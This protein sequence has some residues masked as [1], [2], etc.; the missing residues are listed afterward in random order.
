[1]R[2]PGRLHVCVAQSAL[3]WVLRNTPGHHVKAVLWCACGAV[4]FPGLGGRWISRNVRRAGL[5][6]IPT[7][8]RELGQLDRLY[9]AQANR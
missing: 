8:H 4:T 6:A 7:W 5:D 3:V 9:Q 2:L 1:M